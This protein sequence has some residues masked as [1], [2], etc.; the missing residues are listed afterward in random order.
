MKIMIIGKGGCGK[1]TIS[2]IL[3]KKLAQKGLSVLVI[4]TDESNFG[5]YT[6][7]G[8]SEPI[9]L[10]DQLGGKKDV[11]TKVREAKNEGKADPV[12]NIF[13]H[14]WGIS[15]IPEQCLSKKDGISLMQIGKVKHFNEG[16]ACPMGMLSRG[17]LQNLVL[18]DGEVAIVDTEA[19]V[20]HV[21]RGV[22]N[23]CDLALMIIDPSFESVRLSEKVAD[24]LEE[25]KKPLYYV[26]NKTDEGSAQILRA[27]VGGSK[28]V[29]VFGNDPRLA[30]AGLVGRE[31]SCHVRGAQQLTN[32][33]MTRM[34]DPESSG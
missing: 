13:D 15:D 19:G 16:C 18:K 33:I 5:L 27:K 3:A 20:E 12:L 7:L 29:S 23:G 32:F 8:V 9:E 6:Q 21:G 4:D 26:L 28:V 17:F 2:S 30:K 1:S 24:M 22:E 10:M 11:M 34:S 25:A 14:P 31:I